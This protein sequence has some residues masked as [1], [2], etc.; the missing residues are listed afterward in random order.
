MSEE[1]QNQIISEIINKTQKI[2]GID[3]VYFIDNNFEIIKEEKKTNCSNYLPEVKN[4]VKSNLAN[5]ESIAQDFSLK[6]FHTYTFLNENG[7]ILVSHLHPKNLHMIIV[8]GENEPADLI[9]L[10]KICKEARMSFQNT[11]STF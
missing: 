4:I 9:S 8:A 3:V 10:L 5:I 1:E 11:L 6:S 7:L 2:S